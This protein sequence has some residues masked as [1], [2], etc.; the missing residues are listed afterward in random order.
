MGSRETRCPMDMFLNEYLNSAPHLQ[1]TRYV[2]PCIVNTRLRFWW[3]QPNR[4]SRMVTTLSVKP[5][6]RAIA[7]VLACFFSKH[8]AGADHLPNWCTR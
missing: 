5:P 2:R 4:K 3:W 7:D 6:L 1:H 8:S